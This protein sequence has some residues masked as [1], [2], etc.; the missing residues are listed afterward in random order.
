MHAFSKFS[1]GIVAAL[2]CPHAAS[3]KTRPFDV[4]IAEAYA[5]LVHHQITSSLPLSPHPPHLHSAARAR[6]LDPGVPEVCA[7]A[8]CGL[9]GV[10]LEACSYV[11]PY[12][13]SS[14][15]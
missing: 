5:I 10:S 15:A 6:P 7:L 8:K 14:F 11:L 2:V 1:P 9:V 12:Y 4:R 13:L 3:V